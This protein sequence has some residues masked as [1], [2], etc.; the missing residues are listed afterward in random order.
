MG[1][2]NLFDPKKKDVLDA[3][4]RKTWQNPEEILGV[5]ETKPVFVAADI[6]SGSGF[7]AL[8]LSKK[9]TK[10]YAVDVQL[11]MLKALEQK[12]RKL[13]IK[14]IEMLLAGQNE[15]PLESRS[16]D[17]LL[18]V[19]TLHEFDDKRKMISE[20]ARV[21]KEGGK[22]VISD[23]KKENTDFGPP[24]SIRVAKQQ[25]IDMFK[26]DFNPLKE[27]NLQYHYLLTFQKK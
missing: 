11:E 10:V 23:W 22:A 26:E 8:P 24:T 2:S 13:G 18:S 15:I 16:V 12:I 9:V 21:L 14:N 1:S 5:V 4:E 7:L 19:N 27:E 6:G 20:M 17:I 25:A 3:V